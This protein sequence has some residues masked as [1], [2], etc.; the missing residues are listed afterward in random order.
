MSLMID[1]EEL[2]KHKERV[3]LLS[4]D[5]K[6]TCK[7]LQGLCN[8]IISA[9]DPESNKNKLSGIDNISE[10][11]LFQVSKKVNDHLNRTRYLLDAY[12]EYM[13]MLDRRFFSDELNV[14]GDYPFH[15]TSAKKNIR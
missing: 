11:L 13:E 7:A 5:V 10:I 9:Q 15:I 4:R 6:K 3:D 1:E 2:R 14:N 8:E 12:D